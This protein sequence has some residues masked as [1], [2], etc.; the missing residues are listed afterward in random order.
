MIALGFK[1]IELTERRRRYFQLLANFDLDNDFLSLIHQA[2]DL[3]IEKLNTHD[4]G[5]RLLVVFVTRTNSITIQYLDNN[6]YGSQFNAAVLLY[7]NMEHLNDKYKLICIVEEFVHHFYSVSDEV[8]T[9]Q[10]VCSLIPGVTCDSS[11][12]YYLDA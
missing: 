4:R 11:G 10:I 7:K 8:E 5:Y 9:S 1:N 6:Q 3:I 2:M 12:V